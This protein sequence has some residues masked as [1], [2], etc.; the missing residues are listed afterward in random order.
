MNALQKWNQ[1]LRHE[2]TNLLMNFP[3]RISDFFSDVEIVSASIE[4]RSLKNALGIQ[5]D[6]LTFYS[7]Y[8]L[9]D[10]QFHALN[11]VGFGLLFMINAQTV[12]KFFS[13]SA[14]ETMQLGAFLLGEFDIFSACEEILQEKAPQS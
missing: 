12:D 14:E 6:E 11:Y 8:F 2:R 9:K 7:L 3:V 1:R 4:T 13:I 10:G 5:Y